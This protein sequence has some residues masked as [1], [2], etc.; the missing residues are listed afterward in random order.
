MFSI[1]VKPTKNSLQGVLTAPASKSYTQR[2]L[3]AAALSEGAG[4]I[5][6]P[7]LSE[8]TLATLRAVTAF[9]AQVCQTKDCWAVQGVN[10]V[11]AADGLVDVG[12]SGATLRFMIPIAALAVGQS[13]FLVSR[14]L[15]RRPIEPLFSS[16]RML[17]VNVYPKQVENGQVIVVE[18]KGLA[19]G[20][21]SLPGDVSSQF[22]SGLMFACPKAMLDT[23]IHVTT[24][25]ESIDYVKMT[26]KVLA[27]HQINVQIR[28]NYRRIRVLG[29][30]SF[31]P[32]DCKV[33]GDFS[34]AAFLLAAAAI[35]NSK[36][37]INNLDYQTVQGDKAIL[38]LLKQ[39]G[40]NMKIKEHSVEVQGVDDLLQ[41]IDIDATNIPDLVPICAVLACYAQGES[42]IF[43][44]QR[45]RFKESDRLATVCEEL[46]K[47][48]ALI[49]MEESGLTIKGP[50]KLYGATINPHNDHRIAMS[51]T[52]AALRAEGETVVENADCIRK[53]YPL[54]YSDLSNIGAEIVG[55]ELFR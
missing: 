14:S 36:M 48:G 26:Q 37:L 40:V 41:A 47:M 17:G 54:F 53:S 5:V 6:D 45:L 16:L 4:K 11:K 29:G 7:L 43:N 20:R 13:T 9:G 30:Q 15:E 10:Q 32:V 46:T 44:A 31:K 24:L 12:E 51:C 25:L 52:V 33:S 42:K 55:G 3:I 39:M 28:E 50:C 23:E 49:S 2:M 34:S 1:T 21:T 35:T 27:Q 8:D 19:G 22:V 38:D 18:G